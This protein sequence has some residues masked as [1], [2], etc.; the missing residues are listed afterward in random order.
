MD[1]LIVQDRIELPEKQMAAN[2]PHLDVDED[3]GFTYLASKV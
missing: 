3:L 2:V 1:A